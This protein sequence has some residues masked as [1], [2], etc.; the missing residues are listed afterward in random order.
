MKKV[1]MTIGT[2]VL[3]M[4]MVACNG[5]VDSNGLSKKY[6]PKADA[7][8]F[9]SKVCDCEKLENDDEIEACLVDAL[10]MMEAL[11]QKY[12]DDEEANAIIEEAVENCECQDA[13]GSLFFYALFSG[14]GSEEE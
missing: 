7:D 3:V 6:N 12:K 11:E 5:N 9:I 1:M 14:M 8:T 4:T 10:G 2:L 13:M